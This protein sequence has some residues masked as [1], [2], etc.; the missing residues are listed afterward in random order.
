MG[1]TPAAQRLFVC[2]P[3]FGSPH[4]AH[5]ANLLRNNLT[6]ILATSRPDTWSHVH[7]RVCAYEPEAAGRARDV[8]ASVQTSQLHLTHDVVHEEGIVGDFLLRHARPEDVDAYDRVMFFLDDIEMR[9]DWST[10]ELV[11]LQDF[12]HM[13]IVSPCL[14]PASPT[15]FAYMRKDV[16]VPSPFAN[17]VCMKVTPAC[18]FFC[19]LL[20]KDAYVSKYFP[21]LHPENPW[22]WGLDM[23]LH[24]HVG[25]RVG[26]LNHVAVQHHYSGSG[27]EHSDRPGSRGY[28]ILF[29]RF[30]TS[31]D[32][33]AR[34]PAILYW[35][36]EPTG[37]AHASA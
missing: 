3:G 27:V 32:E 29:S 34:Q 19:Y 23:L 30:G 18:E 12:F 26:I 10:H 16:S 36:V 33:L 1:F 25:L 37:P 6:R 31:M 17:A 5:K 14:T 8:L 2:V 22:M 24:A 15:P 11:R 20:R 21:Q 35:V 7:V 13:D 9:E 28:E 4:L